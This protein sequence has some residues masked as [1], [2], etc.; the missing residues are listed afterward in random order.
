MIAAAVSS[1]RTLVDDVRAV[2]QRS[3]RALWERQNDDGTW[4]C[5]N[6]AGPGVTAE[7][8]IALRFAGALT[9]RLAERCATW[10]VGQQRDDGSFAAHPHAARGCALATA[11]CAAALRQCGVGDDS[12]ARSSA[13][14]FV[15]RS[16]GV[17]ALLDAQP[18]GNPAALLVAIAGDIDPRRLAP[19]P[20]VAFLIDPVV[21]LITRRIHGG[22]PMLAAQLSAVTRH[23][24]GW[25]AL[26]RQEQR[27]I[28]ELVGEYQSPD[29][30]WMGAMS[31]TALALIA[32]I[33]AGAPP[34][35]ARVSSAVTWILAQQRDDGA[36]TRFSPFPTHTWTTSLV[37][38]AG[39]EAGMS[40]RD[41][42]AARAVA[43]LAGEQSRT[44]QSRFNH[45]GGDAILT[46]G[47]SFGRG[48]HRMVD[49]DTS[50][51][52]LSA[53]ATAIAPG[54]R[55][56]RL[57][58]A[59]EQQAQQALQ[60]GLAWLL[61]MQNPEGGWAAY[62]KGHRVKPRGPMFTRPV[63]LPRAGDARAMLRFLRDP[64]AEVGDPATEDI[65][66]RALFT[67]GRARAAGAP[68]AAARALSFL[69]QQQCDSGAFWSRWVV[70]YVAGT[71]YV[72]RGAG[73]VGASAP[74]LTAAQR[75]LISAQQA[76]GGWGEHHDAL[77]HPSRA[78]QGRSTAPLTGLA[79]AALSDTGLASA[80]ATLRGVRHLRDA[81]DAEG[82]WPNGDFMSS[83]FPPDTFYELG[84]ARHVNP[85]EGLSRWLHAQGVSRG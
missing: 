69:E 50:A 24:T 73:A 2:V 80:P 19:P 38:R 10:L 81:V 20:R 72:L 62:V 16:G 46:G 42:R 22:F 55:G 11:V 74:W 54:S 82:S 37:L 83:L 28:L 3:A 63:R 44:P 76:D 21:A 56:N 32:L 45:R 49:C 65:T 57:P 85:L 70:C 68:A 61:D 1:G 52:A 31:F 30:S 53:L 33:A 77:R 34:G 13:A 84:Q 27:R 5:D 48:A 4:E 17:E 40:R 23:L 67:L 41:G 9:P 8:V 58:A 66:A 64:P 59:T 29:G 26:E 36:G 78:G 75:W 25:G 39:L 47:Y 51:V 71:S 15:A 18:G 35:D 43:W 60:R 12:D 14:R 79:V 6:D 7:V